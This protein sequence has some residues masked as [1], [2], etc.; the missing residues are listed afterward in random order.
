MAVRIIN[1]VYPNGS[2]LE[3]YSLVENATPLDPGSLDGGFGQ[4]TWTA[5]DW[6]LSRLLIDDDVVLID[7]VKGHTSATVRAVSG[8]NGIVSFTAD[9][10]LG[11]FNVDR[12]AQ[13]YIGSLSGLFRYYM[14][15][16]GI[17]APLSYSAPEQNVT[18]PGFVGNVWDHIKYLCSAY[19]VELA[20]VHDSVSVRS[21]RTYQAYTG[22]AIDSNFDVSTQAAAGAVEVNYYNHYE[23][24]DGEVF[25]LNTEEPSI[26]QVDANETLTW[27]I[28]LNAS[29]S[30]VN[31]PVHVYT[32]GP[33]NQSGTNG[34]YTVV[35][36]DD[37]PITPAQWAAMGGDLRVE[38]TEDPRV[39]NVTVVGMNYARLAP[40]RIAMSAGGTDYNS[41]HITGTGVAFDL[42]T[43][44]LYTGA[45]PEVVQWSAERL[46]SAKAASPEQPSL[47]SQKT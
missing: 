38:L 36:N 19:Q 13:P 33:E 31:Q 41:L 28:E 2:N 47:N 23:I 9:N 8:G 12:T 25:P 26:Q 11:K 6:P 24:V 7:D 14:D 29:L 1:P 3:G 35:G 5:P 44:V 21:P 4:L 20:F 45:A 22:R 18:V 39:V 42:R 27:S 17:F 43:L 32:V 34:V 40:F 30:S 37:L 15:L 10:E 46:L 16:V